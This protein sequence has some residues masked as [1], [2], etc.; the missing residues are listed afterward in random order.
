MCPGR[1]EDTGLL[2][3]VA[4]ALLTARGFPEPWFEGGREEAM[5]TD[6]PVRESSRTRVGFHIFFKSTGFKRRLS[7]FALLMCCFGETMAF[8]VF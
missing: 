7:G 6:D 8:K 2:Q 1:G 5:G 4:P 3:L